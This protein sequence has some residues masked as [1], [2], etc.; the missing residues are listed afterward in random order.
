MIEGGRRPWRG[1]LVPL[2]ALAVATAVLG[3]GALFTRSADPPLPL[4][5]SIVETFPPF[6]NRDYKTGERYLLSLVAPLDDLVDEPQV[7]FVDVNDP[8]GDARVGTDWTWPRVVANQ[9]TYVVDR[10]AYPLVD[11]WFYTGPAEYPL[12]PE[13]E[14]SYSMWLA[15]LDNADQQADVFETEKAA[16]DILDGCT[17]Q[18]DEL[19]ASVPDVIELPPLDIGHPG[20]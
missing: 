5:A 3:L 4:E 15:V 12:T 10:G 18:D 11:V 6:L 16:A 17:V 1:L 13:D 19:A 2:L 8:N 7:G 20:F 14:T 9:C